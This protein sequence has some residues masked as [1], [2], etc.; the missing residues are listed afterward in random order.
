MTTVLSADVFSVDDEDEVCLYIYR[1][2]VHVFPRC[3]PPPTDRR[4]PTVMSRQ[5]CEVAL[6]QTLL[7]SQSHSLITL[8]FHVLSLTV[9]VMVQPTGICLCI[10]DWHPVQFH[11][12]N[13]RGIVLLDQWVWMRLSH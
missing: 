8:D 6:T 10:S 9:S 12:G 5:C 7:L 1:V 13:S 2:Y 3:G 11:R 4:G